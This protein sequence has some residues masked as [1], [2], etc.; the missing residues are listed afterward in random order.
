MEKTGGIGKT[1]ATGA[2]ENRPADPVIIGGTG[3]S[4]TRVV[5]EIL[6]RAGVYLGRDLND[7]YDE[8]LFPYLFN[9]PQRFSDSGIFSEPEECRYVGLV[10][11][12]NKLYRKHYPNRLWEWTVVLKSAW[13]HIR[14]TR[15]VKWVGR[16]WGRFIRNRPRTAKSGVGNHRFRSSFFRD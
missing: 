14:R 6:L 15:H 5:A 9:I 16:R 1:M 8:C 7:S 2:L 3:G 4:G 12:H 10:G 11:L 13:F